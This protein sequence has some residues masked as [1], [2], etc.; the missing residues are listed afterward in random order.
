[1]YVLHLLPTASEADTDPIVS[2][3]MLIESP[4][5]PIARFHASFRIC[6]AFLVLPVPVKKKIV[7]APQ[8]AS[9]DAEICATER[10]L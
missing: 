1:M 8:D 3:G 9:Q 2:R 4:Q 6:T 10:E 7:H 5:S